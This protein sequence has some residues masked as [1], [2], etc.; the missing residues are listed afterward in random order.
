MINKIN[1]Q[2]LSKDSLRKLS[3]K[4]M[5]FLIESFVT[6]RDDYANIANL[7]KWDED[8]ISQMIDSD[9]V[10]GKIMED[11]EAFIEIT[12]YLLFL[13]LLR[14]T[15]KEQQEDSEFVERSMDLLNSSEPL[16]PWNKKRLLDLMN[17]AQVANYIANMLAQF[18][19]SSCLF[20]VNEGDKESYHYIV[21]MI[22][23]SLRSDNVRKFNIYCHIGDYT[24]FLIGMIPEYIDYRFEHRRAVDKDYY[25][26]FG[27]AYYGLASEHSNARK[28]MLSD[29]LA[30]LSEAFEIVVQIL[31]IMNKKYLFQK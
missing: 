21:D 27:K 25:I 3:D 30:Q 2:D 9:R 10:F 23:D 19:K 31:H 5:L 11:S 7:V 13:L 24:L 15:L 6:K 26:G 28:N 22:E 4:D 17:D 29:T 1:N 14:R 8:I 12:P 20:K 16:I 18:T